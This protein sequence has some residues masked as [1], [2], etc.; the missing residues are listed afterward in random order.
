MKNPTEQ[1]VIEIVKESSVVRPKDLDAHNVP[2]KYLSRLHNKG[3]LTKV[4]R[5]LYTLAEDEPATHRTLAEVSKRIPNAIVCLLSA[6]QFH[7]ISTQMP[8]EVWIA[9]DTKAWRPVEKQLPIRIVHFSGE[10]LSEGVE[11]HLIEGVL[12]KVYT[13]AKTVADCFKYRN[14]IGLDVALEAL[15]DAVRQKKCTNDDLYRYAKICRVW[16]VMKPYMESVD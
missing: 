3:L 11:E 2:R 9:V 12:V 16:K 14:K 5:G 13:P 4:S 6:L 15:R 8:F 10:A 1:K 7:E